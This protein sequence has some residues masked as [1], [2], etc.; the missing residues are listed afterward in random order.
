MENII[1]DLSKRHNEPQAAP[2][3]GAPSVSNL[4]A[5]AS[6][7]PLRLCSSQGFPGDDAPPLVGSG[8]SGISRDVDSVSLG[9]CR[10]SLSLPT[11]QAPVLSWECRQSC[12]MRSCG[13]VC[14]ALQAWSQT[15]VPT[16]P[17]PT[18]PH[19]LICASDHVSYNADK[20]HC[21]HVNRLRGEA[22]CLGWKHKVL[23]QKGNPQF[24]QSSW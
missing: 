21:L 18:C 9:S 22:Q 6:P 12:T 4:R 13:H 20:V 7:W 23:F 24:P 17:T 5:Q 16:N 19:L 11:R 8:H 1:T 2:T 10:C 14:S 15:P 3:S